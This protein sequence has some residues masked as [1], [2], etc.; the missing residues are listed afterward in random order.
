MQPVL[1][2]AAL[3][4]VL[5]LVSPVRLPA[6][7]TDTA[8]GTW[9]LNLAK[10]TYD[11]ANLAPKSGMGKIESIEGGLKFVNDGVDSAGK[12][13]HSEWSGKYDGKDN[14]VKGDPT[15]DTAS[16]KKIDDY[17]YEIISKKAGKVVTT[18]RTVYARDAKSRTQTTTG[19]NAQG[20]NI[21]N[22]SVS[23]KQ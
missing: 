6:Q 13:T 14:A 22:V 7:A 8:N 16:L 4:F 3:G 18:N 12:P 15:R 17:T 10:S 5:A 9:K 1:R 21:H 11:P 2:M 23:D 19:T 20:Q